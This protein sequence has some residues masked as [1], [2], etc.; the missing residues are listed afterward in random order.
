M[1]PGAIITLGDQQY[2]V[3]PINLRIDF[4]YKEQ[5]AT[6]CKPEG[7]AGF[8]EYVSAAGDI[9]FALVQRNYPEMTRDQFNELI[10]LPMLRPIINGMLAISGY[11]AR[12][13]EPATEASAS[14]SP[15]PVSSDLSTP[16]PDGS[17]TTSSTD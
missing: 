6:V 5:I 16:P 14:P 10:D 11:V 4:A 7:E 1:I 15:E 9:L 2:T 13:L 12:P 17:P 3:P 8:A